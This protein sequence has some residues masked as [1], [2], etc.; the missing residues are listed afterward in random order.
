MILHKLYIHS[1]LSLSLFLFFLLTE[2]AIG[3]SY[4]YQ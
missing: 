1:S 2:K 4:N 3:V